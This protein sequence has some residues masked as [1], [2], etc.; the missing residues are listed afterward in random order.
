MY[1]IIVT[2]ERGH[3]QL[4]QLHVTCVQWVHGLAFLG[5]LRQIYALLAKLE[6]GRP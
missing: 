6:R 3:R 1:V 4:E 5:L 2:L